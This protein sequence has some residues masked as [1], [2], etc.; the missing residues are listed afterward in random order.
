M[1]EP[2]S[3]DRVFDFSVDEPHLAYDFFAPT[4]LP[5]YAD[6]PNNNNGWLEA[7]D[8]LMGELE[9]MV[10]EQMIILA[11]EEVV[12]PMPLSIHKVGG[13]SIVAV[14]GSSFPL[15]APGLSVPPTV[16]K[17]LSTRPDNLEYG[18]GQL[19]QRVIQG[20]DA[21]IATGITV[22]EVGP[23]IV[24]IE[25]QMQVMAS[26]MIQVIGADIAGVSTAERLADTAT[27]DH[28]YRDE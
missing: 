7:D 5:G 10:D 22:R 26:Q 14:E 21:E 17:E 18:H 9:A 19:V 13:P 3:P 6:N 28:S 24:S 25:G 27:V 16:I 15:P 4:P 23:R 8:Y 2:L 12:E 11:V 20:S 1:G